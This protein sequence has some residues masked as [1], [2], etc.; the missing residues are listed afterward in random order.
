MLVL[1]EMMYCFH[2]CVQIG[3]LKFIVCS[4]EFNFGDHIRGNGGGPLE[5][6]RRLLKRDGVRCL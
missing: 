2:K 4:P 3:I 6:P 1:C 5:V